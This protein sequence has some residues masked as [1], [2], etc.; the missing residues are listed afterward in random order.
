MSDR[1]PIA[2]ACY[3]THESEKQVRSYAQRVSEMQGKT[4]NSL[5]FLLSILAI[6]VTLWGFGYKLSLYY[7]QSD[8]ASRSLVAK[9][10]VEQRQ[11]SIT[12]ASRLE[13][14]TRL[15]HSL[16]AF[17]ISTSQPSYPYCISIHF[18]RSSARSS[19]S[20]GFPTPSR[21]PPLKQYFIV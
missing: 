16:Q 18:A 4:S 20:C 8:P 3:D 2:N 15:E 6:A 1:R 5:T 9:L 19:A 7:P 14:K 11:I 13:K 17:V 21:A 12:T 10:W